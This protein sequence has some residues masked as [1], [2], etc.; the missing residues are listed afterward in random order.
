V[1]GNCRSVPV[2][3]GGAKRQSVSLGEVVNN[4][5]RYENLNISSKK[6]CG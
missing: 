2:E 4:A 6:Q 1:D 3:V 5:N